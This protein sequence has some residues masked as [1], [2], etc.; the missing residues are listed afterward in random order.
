MNT[1][2]IPVAAIAGITLYVGLYHL[3]IYIKR[4]KKNQSDLSFS[5]TCFVMAIYDLLCLGAYNNTGLEKGLVWQRWQVATLSLI[6]A[7]FI[8]FLVDYAQWESKRIRNIFTLFFVFG[9]LFVVVDNTGLSWQVDHPAIKSIALPFNL[10]VTYYEVVPGPIT[11]LLSFMGILTFVY[12]FRIGIFLQKNQ[13]R[14]KAKP[15]LYSVLFYCIGLCND[16]AVQMG[17]YRSI[18]LIEYT[19]LG[20]VAMMAFS[21]SHEVLKNAEMKEVIQKA[22]QEL[23]KASQTLSGSS[24]KFSFVTKEIDESINRMFHATQ[25]QYDHIQNVHKTIN[26]LLND[27]HDLSGDIQ[28]S[29]RFAQD[30]TEKIEKNIHTM[31]IAF[32][33]MKTIE[34]S[35]SQIGELVET[36]MKHSRKIDTILE[37]IEDMTSRVNVL[38]LNASIEA[39]RESSK[40][41]SMIIA[42]EIRQLA[43]ITKTHTQEIGGLL[44]T[45][46]QNIEKVK[47]TMIQGIENVQEVAQLTGQ[48]EQGLNEILKL[49][50]EEETRLH[51]ISTQIFE[52]RTFSQQV[53]KEMESMASVS[54]TNLKTAT[55]VNANTKTIR[56]QLNELVFLSESLHRIAEMSEGVVLSDAA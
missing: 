14:S 9:A 7:T 51:R 44:N 54:K 34:N 39:T 28:Q 46:Q 8:W 55:E 1:I 48:G 32:E 18:Y 31:K 29:Y 15:L 37:L 20:I 17:L 12:A 11:Q 22:Y 30:T 40:S 13:N 27:I 35:V 16:A 10:A 33:Q 43:N 53:E 4:Q 2:S 45:F 25:S 42:N 3:L 21:L 6:G 56:A 19:Y 38:S 50:E 24:E 41:G 26:D 36:L 23:L 5:I 47:M 52:L 49:I